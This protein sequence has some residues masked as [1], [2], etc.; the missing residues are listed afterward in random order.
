M[1]IIS[2]LKMP[3]EK[4][5]QVAQILWEGANSGTTEKLFFLEPSQ[6]NIRL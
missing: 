3:Y 5:D 4:Q 1:K 2:G 6:E